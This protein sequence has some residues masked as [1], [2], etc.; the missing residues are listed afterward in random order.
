MTGI[1]RINAER[2]R[3]V[4][5][6]GWTYEHDNQYSQGELVSA[7]DAYL[8]AVE[9]KT[10]TKP[11]FWP[12]DDEWWKPSHDRVRNLEKAGALYQADTERILRNN[13]RDHEQREW[14]TDQVKKIAGMIDTI[15]SK[16]EGWTKG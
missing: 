6:E 2:E 8:F 12:W 4:K 9:K 10:E 1:D 16:K 7:G 14:N 11:R 15:L 3:Q 13:I 5:E